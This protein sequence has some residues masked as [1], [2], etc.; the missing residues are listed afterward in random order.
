MTTRHLHPMHREL[1]D[2]LAKV[3]L[4]PGCSLVVYTQTHMGDPT[5]PVI[6]VTQQVPDATQPGAVSEIVS[7]VTLY[8]NDLTHPDFPLF[9]LR[10]LLYEMARHEVNEWLTVNGK[11]V[12]DPH[13]LTR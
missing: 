8:P 12:T 4:P 7:S 9:R 13:P 3:R 6:E 10:D 5:Y 1:A 11:H 2:R